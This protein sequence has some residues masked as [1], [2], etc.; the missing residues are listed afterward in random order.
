M[1][2]PDLFNALFEI[3]GCFAVF[4]SVR[5]LYIDRSVKGVSPW[6]SVFFTSWG[7]YNL[8]YYPHLSQWLS[9]GGCFLTT[10]MNA[11]WLILYLVFR[12]QRA[13]ALRAALAQGDPFW[14]GDQRTMEA[15][16][17]G[18]FDRPLDGNRYR[19]HDK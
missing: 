8:F 4:L 15:D 19:H 12:V 13:R 16:Q 18:G 17:F 10:F 2:L 3:G 1:Q 6:T 14:S 9:F 11:A 7:F 5:R